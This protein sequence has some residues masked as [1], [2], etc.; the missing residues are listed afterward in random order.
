M[1]R[2]LDL[3]RALLDLIGN[4][5]KLDLDDWVQPVI[6]ATA[7]RVDPPLTIAEA[8]EYFGGEVAT[9]SILHRALRGY[10]WWQRRVRGTAPNMFVPPPDDDPAA[11]REQAMIVGVT[12]PHDRTAFWFGYC[13]GNGPRTSPGQRV[14]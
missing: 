8:R 12:G 6:D 2:W 5:Y 9:W 7:V 1:Q 13:F 11:G 14:S 10:E 4:L 3:R